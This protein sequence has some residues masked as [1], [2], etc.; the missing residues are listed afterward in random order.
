MV[1]ASVRV[2]DQNSRHVGSG[3][4]SASGLFL[5]VGSPGP[6]VPETLPSAGTSRARITARPCAPDTS[7]EIR[8]S[9]LHLTGQICALDRFTSVRCPGGS[10]TL[11]TDTAH[12]LLTPRGLLGGTNKPVLTN[13]GKC[14]WGY[15]VLV[16]LGDGTGL[17]PPGDG[18]PVTVGALA[19]GAHRAMGL[20][21][22]YPAALGLFKTCVNCKRLPRSKS[23][24]PEF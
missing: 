7:S 10:W 4:S 22:A 2:P 8:V 17:P 14:R 21:R 13:T 3:E 16:S 5:R 18:R 23:M 9:T 20:R 15:R 19:R 12:G 6:H 11:D 24:L 1:L